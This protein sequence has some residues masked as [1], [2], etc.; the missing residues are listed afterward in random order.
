MTPTL[1]MPV[2]KYNLVAFNLPALPDE[3]Y[4]W[5]W[6]EAGFASITFNHNIIQRPLWSIA[7][8]ATGSNRPI[9]AG[10]DK[11]NNGPVSQTHSPYELPHSL[12][13]SCE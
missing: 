6:L 13:K 11:H 2:R 3:R 8:L 7:A 12:L 10:G 4:E 5:S 9:A 1:R